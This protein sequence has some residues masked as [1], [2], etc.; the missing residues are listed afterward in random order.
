MLATC[1]GLLLAGV[2]AAAT[3]GPDGRAARQIYMDACASCHGADGRGLSRSQVG[4]NDPLPDFTDCNFAT[5][6][7][8]ADWIAVA[9]QGGPVRGFSHV[10]P[11]F[12]GAL[13]I[14]EITLAVSH[15]RTFCPDDAWPRGELNF[16]RPIITEKAFPEDEAVLTTIVPTEGEADAVD[17]EIVYE[18]R[19]GARNQFELVVPFGWVERDPSG[20]GDGDWTSGIGDIAM[21]VKR[22]V[23]HSMER[24]SILSVTGEVILPTGDEDTGFGKGTAVFEPFVSYGQALPGE[25]FLHGQAGLELPADSDRADE[26]AFL[27]AAIGRTFT[28]G[29]WG[30]AFSPIVE[31]LGARELVGG[32]TTHWDIAPQVQVTLNTRQHITAAFGVRTPLNDTSSRDTQVMAYVL[33]EWFDGNLFEGW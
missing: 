24:G 18:H 2:A 22:A 29:R 3:T 1:V 31:I 28:S 4:F 8:D 14:D 7:P 9:H 26:E 19:F 10:M 12:G 33:W 6:E 5:R 13:T 25:L 17:M 30:R 32:A 20:S 11:S 16:P 21:G 27:R 23:W 15:I